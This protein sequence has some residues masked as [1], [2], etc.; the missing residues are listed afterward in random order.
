MCSKNRYYYFGGIL[1]AIILLPASVP[2]CASELRVF[3][4]AS[5][6]DAL[7]EI[8]SRYEKVSGDRI[9][10]NLGASSTLARQIEEGAPADLFFSADET[11]MDNLEAKG[12]VIK[13]T[14]KTV[15]SNTLVLVVAAEQGAAI[16]CPQDLAG[17]RVKRI[18]LGDPQAVPIGVYAKTY[19]EGLN[20]WKAIR[21]KTVPTENVRAALAAVEAGNADASIVYKTDALISKKVKIVFEVPQQ[22]G[23]KISYPMAIIKDAREP[24]AAQKLLEHLGSEEAAKVFRKFGFIVVDT[25]K[26]P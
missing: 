19:L 5:L 16:T 26:G 1:A 3:A 22:D 4:A 13:Q 17:P 14:R 6:S 25:P 12:L 15:L 18:A 24:Q 21:E 10:L 8:A 20:L 7:K 11:K 2:L 9:S 23:P